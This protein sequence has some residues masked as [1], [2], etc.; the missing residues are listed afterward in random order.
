M[1]PNNPLAL[2]RNAKRQRTGALHDAIAWSRARGQR[3]SVVDCA[4]PLALSHGL[5]GERFMGR[6]SLIFH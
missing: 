6:T 3:V 1:Q 5:A 4:S 2:N